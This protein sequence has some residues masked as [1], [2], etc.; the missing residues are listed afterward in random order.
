MY[1]LLMSGGVVASFL[2]VV[3]ITCLVGLIYVLYRVIKIKQQN[4]G[5]NWKIEIVRLL[6]VCYLTGLLNLTITPQNFW[7]HIWAFVFVGYSGIEL[8]LFDGSL[9]LV[10]SLVRWLQGNLLLGS[11]VKTMLV[12]NILMYIPMGLLFPFTF[13][14]LSR[15]KLWL[16]AVIVPAIIE[17]I[18]P[19]VGRSFD[20]DD[21]ICNFIGIL[22]GYAA[23]HLLKKLVS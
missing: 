3:P 16:T 4:S 15:Q 7:S 19:V 21:L 17:I 12:G 22:L 2:Q 11:W 10:P 6:F 23:A 18:Q 5:I 1:R 13:P 14:R 9:N 20:I 8:T